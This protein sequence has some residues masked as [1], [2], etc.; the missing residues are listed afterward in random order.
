M[1][2]NNE[3]ASKTSH[4]DITKNPEVNNFLKKC[5]FLKVPSEKEVE[6][7]KS[8]F[9]D[10]PNS[11]ENML[12][13]KI[14]A[15]DGSNYESSIDDQFPSTKVGYVKIG[16]VL[17][18]MLQYR[19]LRVHNGRFVDPFKVAALQNNNSPVTFP[20]PSAN[21]RYNGKESVKD[22][23]R[24][25]MDKHL[26]NTRLVESDPNTS[27]RTMLFHLASM[28]SGQM[29]TGDPSV[30]K[31]DKCPN[32]YCTSKG[33]IE[34]RDVPEQQYCEECGKELYPSD[35]L[36][37]W[38]EVSD[39]QSN[40]VPLNRFM[41]LVEHLIPMSYIRYLA[42][43]SLESLVN[44]AFF[45]DGPLAIF[46][47]S[48]WIHSPIMKFIYTVNQKLKEKHNSKLLII[49]LQKSGQVVDHAHLI[50]KYLPENKIFSI[51]DD[52]RYKYILASRDSA[53]NGFGYETYYGQDFIYKTAT[54]RTFVFSLPYPFESKSLSGVDFKK[55]KVE[56]KN[57]EELSRAVTLISHFESD[58][59]KNAVV[60]I[61]LAHKYTAIS[62]AP[63]GQVLDLL[64]RSNLIK[65]Q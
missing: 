55:E 40:K 20:F 1:P 56:I 58:L 18:D 37:I 16:T 25:I 28:R 46:G 62:L 9:I 24:E 22:S 51:D 17:I 6:E 52:Y 35:C 43:K 45:I 57:Y 7:I 61:A 49:G 36:R 10:V 44:L 39:F 2:Y 60:P 23:F 63:G 53:N 12:P 41:L 4:F 13:E 26:Y 5:D 27:L 47:P 11:G 34:L 31:L 30:L 54:G 65:K 29:G 21:I 32:P 33:P 3:F 14:I 19:S 48:A 42:D 38:E 15:M 50:S 64:T 8:H 59:Y